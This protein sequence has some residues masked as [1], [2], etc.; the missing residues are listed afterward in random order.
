[1]KISIKQIPKD[2]NQFAEM[3]KEGIDSPMAICAWLIRFVS[4]CQKGVSWHRGFEF[5]ERTKSYE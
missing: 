3:R 4:V 5:A 2:L 1:M